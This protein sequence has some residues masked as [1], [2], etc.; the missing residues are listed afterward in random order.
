MI[1]YEK[2]EKETDE[3]LLHIFL[4]H[5][6]IKGLVAACVKTND[7]MGSKEGTKEKEASSYHH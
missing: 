4:V 1:W 6:Q 7:K 3:K 2:N 5:L